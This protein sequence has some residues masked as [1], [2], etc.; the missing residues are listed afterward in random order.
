MRR[1]QEGLSE[2]R[3]I[4]MPYY[5]AR[6]LYRLGVMHAKSGESETAQ[7]A[8]REAQA[9]FQRLGAMPYL[10]RTERLLAELEE[11]RSPASPG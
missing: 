3:R 9:I 11:Q 10:E 1:F 8:L 5:E 2:A 7:E 4:G 6:I